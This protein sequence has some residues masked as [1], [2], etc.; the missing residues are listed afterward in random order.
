LFSRNASKPNATATLFDLYRALAIWVNPSPILFLF[1]VDDLTLIG[2]HGVMWRKEED[3]M[4][5][6]PIAGTR[7]EARPSRK[8]R[9]F[10]MNYSREKERAEHVMLV[11]LGA[12]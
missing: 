5:L 11:D 12:Q 8:D 6:R 10:P 3:T 9:S 2:S 1:E 7:R 4:E